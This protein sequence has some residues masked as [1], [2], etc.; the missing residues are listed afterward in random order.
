M[1]EKGLHKQIRGFLAI[2]QSQSGYARYPL[3]Y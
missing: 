2:W 1:K 3:T